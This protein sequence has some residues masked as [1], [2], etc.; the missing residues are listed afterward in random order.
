MNERDARAEGL[1]FTGHYSHDKEDIKIKALKIRSFGFR[2]IVVNVPTS[3][4]SR[5][6]HGMGYSVYAEPAYEVACLDRQRYEG[7]KASL[8]NGYHDN[9]IAELEAKVQDAKNRKAAAEAIVA[10]SEPKAVQ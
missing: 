7:A 9:E 8:E 5:G 10:G 4:L 3:K 1:Q 2:A 6:S